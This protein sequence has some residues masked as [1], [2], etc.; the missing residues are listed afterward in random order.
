MN[1]ALGAGSGFALGKML[2]AGPESKGLPD[3]SGK[4]PGELLNK[5]AEPLANQEFWKNWGAQNQGK[6]AE[7]QANRVGD[8]NNISDFRNNQNIA[9]SFNQ[10]Q[11]NDYKNTVQ[12]YWA[13][14]AV[15][16]TNNIQ[17]SFDNNFNSG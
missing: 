11:W 15:E 14:R 6:L 4:G 17:N 2:G 3:F 1:G 8:W 5:A 9:N 16:V 12:N 13:N 7:F 10:P